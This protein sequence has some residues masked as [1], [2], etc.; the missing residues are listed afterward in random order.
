MGGP[1]GEIHLHRGDERLP[2]RGLL[3]DADIL[4]GTG[5]KLGER[6]LL[7][8][9]EQLRRPPR[10]NR[11]A[12]RGNASAS[13]GTEAYDGSGAAVLRRTADRKRRFCDQN[14][15]TWALHVPPHMSWR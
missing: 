4:I 6:R 14:A 2:R 5:T 11:A 8:A 9:R 3:R 1:R 13:E 7:V 10:W 12:A 15:D